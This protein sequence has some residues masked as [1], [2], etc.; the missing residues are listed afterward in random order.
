MRLLLLTVGTAGERVG[1]IDQAEEDKAPL[2]QALLQLAH[3]ADEVRFLYRH[4]KQHETH[5]GQTAYTHTRVRQANTLIHVLG[6]HSACGC[7]SASFLTMW[8]PAGVCRLSRAV[9]FS[10]RCGRLVRVWVLSIF[11]VV[12]FRIDAVGDNSS[13]R[14]WSCIS[15]GW[16]CMRLKS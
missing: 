7:C 13:P 9:V 3:A 8:L 5:R 2:G 14:S 12:L 15:V 6:V 11:S 16:L 4:R 1:S 10:N